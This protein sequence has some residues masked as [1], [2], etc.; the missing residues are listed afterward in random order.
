MEQ[1]Q[2]SAREALTTSHSLFCRRLQR[3]EEAALCHERLKS[4]AAAAAGGKT[5]AQPQQ[6]H[7]RVPAPTRDSLRKQVRAREPH[8]L[9][10]AT[11]LTQYTLAV[12]PISTP[13]VS[14]KRDQAGCRAIAVEQLGGAAGW[15]QKHAWKCL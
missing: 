2:H 10:P 3:S 7:I 12:K 1:F 11:P 13:L 15:T 8:A 14:P 4:K 9:R 6:R 5:S